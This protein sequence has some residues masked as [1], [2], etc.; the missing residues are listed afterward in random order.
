[1]DKFSH[2]RWHPGP[3][4]PVLEACRQWFAGRVLNRFDVGDHV[5]F[6]VEPFAAAARPLEG[7]LGFQDVRGL[8]PGHPP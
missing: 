5:A 7:Q 6:L 2:C 4:G 3:A 1:V 8:R